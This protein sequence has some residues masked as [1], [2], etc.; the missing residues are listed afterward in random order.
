MPVYRTAL[1]Q[2]G[3][4]H[5]LVV[6]ARG[7]DAAAAVAPE[8]Q[9]L[10]QHILARRVTRQTRPEAEAAHLQQLGPVVQAALGDPSNLVA[11]RLGGEA[12]AHVPDVRCAVELR[13]LP[14]RAARLDEL[15]VDR[16]LPQLQVLLVWPDVVQ[17]GQAGRKGTDE[18]AALLLDR[19]YQP[20]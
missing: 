3:R 15:R 16:P 17:V 11:S 2:H 8:Q 10:H 1:V 5:L 19:L 12:L 14:G 18:P 6:G 13:P 20:P 7:E 9:E 4:W